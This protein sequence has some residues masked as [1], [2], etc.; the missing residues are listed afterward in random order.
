M[1]ITHE[2][3]EMSAVVKCAVSNHLEHS[4]LNLKVKVKFTI[5]KAMNAQRGLDVYLYSFFYLGAR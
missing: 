5:E 3:Q 1:I 4:G 2:F